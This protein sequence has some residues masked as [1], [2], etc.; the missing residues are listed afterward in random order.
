MA[1]VRSSH[2]VILTELNLGGGHG[3]PYLAGEPSWPSTVE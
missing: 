3:I 1:D 2:G